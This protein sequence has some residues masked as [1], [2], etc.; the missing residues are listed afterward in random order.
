MQTTERDAL[1]EERRDLARTKA[2]LEAEITDAEERSEQ[3]Q[4]SRASLEAKAA[5]LDSRIGIAEET[6][7]GLIPQLEDQQ[8]LLSRARAALEDTKAKSNVLF[9]KQARSNQFQTRA[10]RD[11]A[12]EAEVKSLQTYEA[13]Q[14]AR[15]L[16][17]LTESRET[18]DKLLEI[19][20]S[21]ADRIA[22][23]EESKASAE[24]TRQRWNEL[25]AEVDQLVDRRK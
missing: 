5:D 7:M 17:I 14:T 23:V 19:E 3:S 13:S 24:H 1:V 10:Q 21:L 18:Q 12:L 2:K 9:A 15:R 22:S 20:A 16:E 25:Q 8:K 11:A 4:E 6:L